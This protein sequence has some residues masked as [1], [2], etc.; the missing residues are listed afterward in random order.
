MLNVLPSEIGLQ[1]REGLKSPVLVGLTTLA[2]GD[3]VINLLNTGIKL[4]PI[5]FF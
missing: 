1:L 2:L 5:I 4:Y 3:G